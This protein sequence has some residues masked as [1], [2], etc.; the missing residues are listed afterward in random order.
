MAYWFDPF[1]P[2]IQFS[3]QL[4]LRIEFGGRRF[5]AMRMTSTAERV[6]PGRLADLFNGLGR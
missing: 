4:G 1:D 3:L 5:L 6:R 2:A